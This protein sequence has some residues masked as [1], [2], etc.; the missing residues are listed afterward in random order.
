[1][2]ARNTVAS[3]FTFGVD[4]ALLWALVEHAGVTY[5]PAAT[6]S[7]LVAITVHYVLSRTWVFRGT[8][9]GV[10]R[11]YVYFLLNAGIGLTITLAAF[12]ALL[13]FTELFYLIARALASVAA[14]VVVFFLNAVFNFK[15][16]SQ[17]D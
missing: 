2:F 7:F 9:R 13:Q 3:F 6:V 5:I 11:G 14:G 12:A 15:Q 10:A 17:G 1:M 8:E 4:V 16:L